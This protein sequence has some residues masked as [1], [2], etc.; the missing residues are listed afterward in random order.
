MLWQYHAIVSEVRRT[1]TH[2]FGIETPCHIREAIIALDKKNGNT[3]W[4]DALK[5]EMGNVEVAF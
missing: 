1:T 2:I 5:I 4:V 3:L